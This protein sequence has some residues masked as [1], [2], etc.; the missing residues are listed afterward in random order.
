MKDYDIDIQYHLEKANVGIDDL[1]RKKTHSLALITI[2]PR[3]QINFEQVGI[4]MVV[5]G[6]RAQLVKL[7]IQR[8]LRQVGDPGLGKILNEV[9]T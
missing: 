9:T 7:T 4:T 1:C 6:I 5:E 8:T 2:E 3:V